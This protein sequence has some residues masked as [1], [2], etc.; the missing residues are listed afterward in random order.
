MT[1]AM[2][3]DAGGGR[4]D[5]ENGSAGR[6]RERQRRRADEAPSG[7]HRPPI[8]GYLSHLEK[9]AGSGDERAITGI[10]QIPTVDATRALLRL[11]GAAKPAIAKACSR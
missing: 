1:F 8:S 3:S 11:V 4:G 5:R 6:G 7:L 10:G 2:P 9:R